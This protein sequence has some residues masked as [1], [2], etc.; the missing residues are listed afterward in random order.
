MRTS[1]KLVHERAAGPT[2]VGHILESAHVHA[3]AGVRLHK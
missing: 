1:V 2:D 3:C